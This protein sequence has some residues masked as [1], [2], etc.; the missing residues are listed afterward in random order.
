MERIIPQTK[1][2]AR[3]KTNS[4]GKHKIP[5]GRTTISIKRGK[6]RVWKRKK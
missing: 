2:E 6:A 3:K 4:N 1:M 5:S